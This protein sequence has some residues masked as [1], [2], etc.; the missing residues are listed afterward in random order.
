[1]SATASIAGRI[2]LDSYIDLRAFLSRKGLTFEGAGYR[3]DNKSVS[4]IVISNEDDLV[5]QLRSALPD[6]E[7]VILSADELANLSDFIL[8][9]DDSS[10]S[11]ATDWWH[12]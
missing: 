6:F 10:D 1:M 11:P 2:D 9:E 12:Q 3:D 4:M 5:E 7:G 8:D